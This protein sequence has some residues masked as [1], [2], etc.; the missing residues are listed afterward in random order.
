MSCCLLYVVFMS[1]HVVFSCCG[2]V[3]L[4]HCNMVVLLCHVVCCMLFS[5]RVMSGFRVVVLWCCGV[6]ILWC[7][8]VVLSVVG[9][10]CVVSCHVF[11]LWCYVVVAL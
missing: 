1:R 4:W 7:C 9:C 3:A 6:V 2:V 10:F 8:C 11:P 5:Y